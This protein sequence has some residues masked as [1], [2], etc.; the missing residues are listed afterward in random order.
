MSSAPCSTPEC[1]L[2]PNKPKARS[3]WQRSTGSSLQTTRSPAGGIRRRA[4]RATAISRC[5]SRRHSCSGDRN[6]PGPEL[7]GSRRGGL[8]RFVN[9]LRDPRHGGVRQQHVD[10]A[11][12]APD[13]GACFGAVGLVPRR[14]LC[15]PYRDRAARR[16]GLHLAEPFLEWR[17][18]VCRLEHRVMV[19]PLALGAYLRDDPF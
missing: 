16:W 14:N 1:L 7:G 12:P 8:R 5:G 9:Q 10:P 13:V 11:W 3:G 17:P 19:H 18:R 15:R 4:D 2:T 6:R